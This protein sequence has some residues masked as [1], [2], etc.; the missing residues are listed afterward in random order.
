MIDRPQE[1]FVLTLPDGSTRTVAPGTLAGDVVSA[2][3]PGLRRA[4]LAVEVNG[5]VQDLMTPIRESGTFRVITARPPRQAGA[6]DEQR[7][8]QEAHAL[9]RH[10][11]AHILAT[12]VRRLRPKAK[13]GFGPAI[14]DG[15]YYDFEVDEP[16]TPD[17]LA[18]FEAEM[19]T[20][21][22]AKYPFV[23][24][25]VDRKEAERRFV[26]DPLKLERLSELRDD[27][28]ISIYTDGP[29]IDLCRGPHVPDTSYL[30][31]FKLLSTAPAYWRGDEHRQQL[32][33]IYGTAWINKEDLEAYLHRLEEAKRRDHRVL[34][35]AL[36]LYSVDQRVGP[37]LILWH[38]RG[39]IVRNE[40]E[41]FER[42][43]IIRHGYE[44]VY[45][46]HVV[47]EKLF[48]ISG[49]LVNFAESMFGP[50]EVEGASYRPKPMNCPG[51]ICIYQS[52]TRSY[53]DLPIRYAEFGT[54]YRYE[55]SGV[56]HGMLR[57]RGFTQ[58]DAHIFCTP[59]QVPQEIGRLLDLVDEMLTTFG[60]PYSI[61]LSTRPENAMGSAEVWARAERMLADV[62]DA[63]GQPFT[64][65]EGGG[66]FYGP[67]LD[68]K[69]IDAIGRKWQGPTVQLDFN[70]PERF[71][72]EYV[73]ADNTPHRPVMLHR[74]LVGSMERFVGGLIEHYAGAFP[75]WLA[76]EQLRVI[77]ITDE[78]REAA[79]HVA[80]RAR[81]A[82][83]R[84]ML[85]DRS[86]TLNY[87]IRDA[88]LLKTPYMAIVGARE[89]EAGT[90]ALRMRGAG[91][92]QDV[93]PVTELVAR[94]EREV[95][96]RALTPETLSLEPSAA[97]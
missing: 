1:D 45:T 48:E 73:G 72:L 80:E 96:R 25:E 69:L 7:A 58:D 89:A 57:V 62:L 61:E 39:A 50:I 33:R 76:P 88:E 46:P 37:G 70:L 23:R 47:S 77:P 28:V 79:A 2:I 15:F 94:L 43:L 82:G 14:E 18:A 66:A 63:R 87:R 91:K 36:D 93:M 31:H 40:I 34:G 11:A 68:F 92:K 29:F 97:D 59:E 52:H 17:D 84:V 42:D 16:F 95:A 71:G 30:K 83:I 74:V 67:K 19:R 56:L 21:A 90:V 26:D 8:W 51:H 54:V 44:L 86:E 64:M 65:D 32:Q 20:V 4:A 22:S 38:P 27:E 24:E 81:A 85:D 78:A 12:A 3:G 41:T 53:R 10:S 55:R 49:H 6:A 5:Q 60:Y 13:I 75:L 9:L 35:Q